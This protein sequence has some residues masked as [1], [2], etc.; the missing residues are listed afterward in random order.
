MLFELAQLPIRL[1]EFRCLDFRRAKLLDFLE[2]IVV[3]ADGLA[4]VV[5][6]RLRT[7]H[8]AYALFGRD[9]LVLRTDAV[10]ASHPVLVRLKQWLVQC[11]APHLFSTSHRVNARPLVTSVA[12][13]AP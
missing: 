10:V 8:R 4:G 2:R 6:P 3:D 5:G 1:R 9:I 12:R 13:R 11:F 7:A